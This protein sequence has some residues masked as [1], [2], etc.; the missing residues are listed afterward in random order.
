MRQRKDE[1]SAEGGG[2]V[3]LYQEWK[4][5]RAMERVVCLNGLLLFQIQMEARRI[6]KRYLR[7]GMMFPRGNRRLARQQEGLA[8]SKVVP[9]YS[10]GGGGQEMLWLL[11]IKLSSKPCPQKRVAQYEGAKM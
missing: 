11:L 7:Q 1:A 2:D 3:P 8:S 9:T 10:K 5:R 6:F 4:P